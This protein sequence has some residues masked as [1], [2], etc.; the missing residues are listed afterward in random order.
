MHEL[1]GQQC[2]GV[3]EAQLV[4]FLNTDL[5]SGLDPRAPHGAHLR[6]KKKKKVLLTS[7]SSGLSLELMPPL[8][9]WP[10]ICNLAA[11]P[12]F[13]HLPHEDN[14]INFTELFLPTYQKDFFNFK[15]SEMKK[16]CFVHVW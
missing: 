16:Q 4:K 14:Q 10:W 12:W 13:S 5:S 2:G 1:E 7:E 3:W 6:K 8:T 15:K 9:V 11:K